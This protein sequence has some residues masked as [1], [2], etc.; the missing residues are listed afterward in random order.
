MA[1][2]DQNLK[3]DNEQSVSTEETP[4]RRRRADR[5][6]NEPE[7]SSQ[8]DAA[9][10]ET[11]SATARE[12]ANRFRMESA[13]EDAT[14]RVPA[15]SDSAP[16]RVFNP[17]AESGMPPRGR[18]TSARRPS[19]EQSGDA[20]EQTGDSRVRVGY[21]SGRMGMGTPNWASREAENTDERYNG[22][23]VV[24]K[25]PED[26]GNGHR[27]LKIAV[28]ALIVIGVLIAAA[29]LIPGVRQTVLGRNEV[30]GTEVLVYEAEGTEGT[31][32]AQ[33]TFTIATQ[34]GVTDVRMVD[35]NG[36]AI[37]VTQTV[38]A[39]DEAVQWDLLWQLTD[40]WNGTVRLQT[41]SGDGWRDTDYETAIAIEAQ[42]EPTATPEVTA[43]PVV[44]ATDEPTAEPEITEAP[45]EAPAEDETTEAEE[46]AE[47]E[48][49]G[50]AEGAEEDPDA[51][52]DEDPDAIPDDAAE[53]ETAGEEASD[54]TA[55]EASGEEG[56]EAA[57]VI[58]PTAAEETAAEA[59]ETESVTAE[60]TEAPAEEAEEEKVLFTVEAAESAD[61][62]LITS[63]TIYNGT[64]KVTE[65]ARSSKE[66]VHMPTLGE[67]TRK[68]VGI[69]TFRTDAFRQNAAIGT[70]GGLS[71]LSVEWTAEAGSV[72][73]ANQTYYGIG[74]I[75]QPAIVK[76]S[77][78]VREASDMY[79]AK[80]EKSGLKEVIVAGLDGNIYFLDLA[81]G[82][83]TRNQ[84]KVGYPMK[85]SPSL[86]PSG[87]PYMNVGQ[88]ARKM[89][90]GT[91][92][93]GLRQYNL[94]NSKELSLIDG[95]D[96]KNNRV[97]NK[98]GSFETSS[99]I[100]RTSNTMI[101]A[102][103][104]GL[105][106]VVSLNMEFD[107][108]AGT[109]TQ[110]PTFTLLKAK[111][112]GEGESDQ[113]VEASVAMYDKYVFYADM[114]GILRC[115]DT[116]TMTTSWAVKLE[117]AVESTP[118]LDWHGEDGLDLYAATILSNRKK[119]DA[120]VY[121]VDALSGE[122]RWT[123]NFGVKKDTKNKS[124]SGFRASPVVGQNALS[125][126]VYYT[127]NNLNDDGREQLGL[128]E[129]VTA[130]V[131]AM[132]KEDGAVVW[133]KALSGR[134]YSSPVA[135]YDE[136]GNGS[137]IQCAGDGTIVMLDGLTGNQQAYLEVDG[138][139]EG[140]PAVYNSMLVVGTTEKG[141]NYIYGIKIQ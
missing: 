62:S 27:G 46:T 110:S 80:K 25:R 103:T 15:Q 43:L 101:T 131:I 107:Y 69:F 81:D 77:Q 16:A 102:G 31:A 37:E 126:Y 49:T 34:S 91:G 3:N 17:N 88:Y 60:A 55:S 54:E 109:Y 39:G 12:V 121:C 44:F 7:T 76:W 132:R 21:A 89:A 68:P 57:A 100:D 51:I 75:G 83:P 122:I 32:P 93:I 87:A 58:D 96:A 137:I 139:I 40:A 10:V 111:A 48:E 130:A 11:Q 84:I 115:V 120:Q 78:Q 50:D 112:K 97:A 2:M 71:S 73:G 42:P 108:N 8:Q 67:Y 19:G 125:D 9:S 1:D 6:K 79:D 134:G 135:V 63:S 52:P 105:L 64:K 127:V 35:E 24:N 22:K 86:H 23:P 74:Y 65:F 30:A 138:A 29:M 117:D 70:V 4:R 85:G 20:G 106:Y 13:M 104:N 129:D 66:Q 99:L 124:V 18:M 53:D 128:G 95:L 140:S 56:E 118:A 113:A 36:E 119:G 28:A 133:S 41:L 116:N 72:K 61:P 14:K 90:K 38:S 45:T 136:N 82:T 98:I 92:T 59:A 114:G 26:Q 123:A 5:Y 141:S 94:Y 47:T 33:V